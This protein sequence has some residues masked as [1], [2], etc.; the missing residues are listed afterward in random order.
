MISSE[1]PLGILNELDRMVDDFIVVSRNISKARPGTV[2]DLT[3]YSPEVRRNADFKQKPQ[4]LFDTSNDLDVAVA[5]VKAAKSIAKKAEVRENYIMSY[6]DQY[7]DLAAAA[8]E[9]KENDV[10]H[11]PYSWRIIKILNQL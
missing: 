10:D 4:R 7:L 9:Q 5:G 1:T 8:E 11:L 6:D 2:L 3:V